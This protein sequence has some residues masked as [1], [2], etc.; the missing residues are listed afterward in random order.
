MMKERWSSTWM[1]IFALLV[2]AIFFDFLWTYVVI[3]PSCRITTLQRQVYSWSWG[4]L[5]LPLKRCQRKFSR[6][7]QK[8]S[9][10]ESR[11]QRCRGAWRVWLWAT[12]KRKGMRALK[13]V[14]PNILADDFQLLV[15]QRS[16]GIWPWPWTSQL[17]A[18]VERC[19]ASSGRVHGAA[20]WRRSQ[21]F[22][23][24]YSGSK[25]CWTVGDR[26]QGSGNGRN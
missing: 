9:A 6:I 12:S 3:P 18:S 16:T 17:S 15:Q 25:W 13:Y 5:V 1:D 10:L 26:L 7:R 24:R 23:H 11:T 4:T 8:D 22:W 2:F 19:S 20:D 21:C 14:R